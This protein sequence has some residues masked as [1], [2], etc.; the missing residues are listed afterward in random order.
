MTPL[1]ALTLIFVTLKLTDLVQW[2]WWLV[3]SPFFFEWVLNIVVMA[4]LIRPPRR[5]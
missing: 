3:L 4:G 1:S 2:S 5:K